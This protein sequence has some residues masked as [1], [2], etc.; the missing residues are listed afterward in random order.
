[1][2]AGNHVLLESSFV[3]SRK[4]PIIRF[5]DLCECFAA[6]SPSLGIRCSGMVRRIAVV[7]MVL[8]ELLA[9]QPE[10][11]QPQQRLPDGRQPQPESHPRSQLEHRQEE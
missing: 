2:V 6:G 10:Q 8:R 7:T 9:D 3:A 11:D 4:L 5:Q 1:M